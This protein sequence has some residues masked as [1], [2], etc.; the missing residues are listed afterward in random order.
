MRFAL[1][2]LGHAPLAIAAAHGAA[3][4]TR[5][6][7]QLL[8][9]AIALLPVPGRLTT[10]AFAAASIVHFASDPIGVSGSFALHL[11]VLIEAKYSV[12]GA[13]T[14]M[15]LYMITVHIPYLLVCLAIRSRLFA[16]VAIWIASA[17]CLRRRLPRVEDKVYILSET[18]Q[19]IIVSHVLISILFPR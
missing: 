18:H 4:V 19:R 16:I 2:V 12:A 5:P 11:L 14:T 10:S 8:L 3:D 15:L 13:T 6:P 7:Q 1:P 17:V 9:Y